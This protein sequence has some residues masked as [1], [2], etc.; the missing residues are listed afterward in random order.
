MPLSPLQQVEGVQVN[1]VEE[2]VMP[3]YTYEFNFETGE[4]TGKKIDEDD[5]IRQ[6]IHKALLTARSRYLIYDDSYGS[7][8]ESLIEEDLPFEMTATEAQ[9][10]ITEA[11]IYDDRIAEI[12]NVIVDRAVDQL[13]IQ[14]TV[15]TNRGDVIG[16]EMII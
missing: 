10:L 5:A 4:F 2:E 11:L 12:K 13:Y 6:F 7:E 16:E 8:L 15:V 14:V 1:I 9:R 3:S